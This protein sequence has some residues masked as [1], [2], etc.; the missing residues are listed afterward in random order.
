MMEQITGV[1]VV[2]RQLG[3]PSGDQQNKLAEGNHHDAAMAFQPPLFSGA[4]DTTRF[5]P[6]I[7][8]PGL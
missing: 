8:P 2:Y 5:V 7:P 4:G 6:T 1:R 3:E